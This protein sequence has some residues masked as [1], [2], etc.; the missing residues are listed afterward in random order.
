MIDALKIWCGEMS[1]V[2][3]KSTIKKRVRVNRNMIEKW[4]DE[5]QHQMIHCPYQPGELLISMN[6]CI[7]R[8][9]KARGDNSFQVNDRVFCDVLP[10]GLSFC[11][12][13]PILADLHLKETP[14]SVNATPASPA[15]NQH[16]G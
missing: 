4:L 6:S 14:H 9:E 10:N 13:C 16:I 8:H 3:S 12:H 7:R 1:T 2:T 11:R 5:N 15:E